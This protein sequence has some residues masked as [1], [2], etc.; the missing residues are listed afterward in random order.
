MGKKLRKL[1]IFCCIGFVFSG[2][3]CAV[4]HDSL[5][6]PVKILGRSL[7]SVAIL[8][9]IKSVFSTGENSMQQVDSS[10]PL[11]LLK[12]GDPRLYQISEP[13]DL[14]KEMPLVHK[15]L[16]QMKEVTKGI[17][18]V[19]IAAPQIGIFKLMVMFEIPKKHLRYKT[20]G[21][22]MPMRVMINPSYKPLS[23][24]KNFEW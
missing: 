8:C 14:P 7:R 17:G 21:I 11:R 20:D 5:G 13:I 3:I 4:V 9:L 1:I 16:E 23:D 10:R 18:N 22:A 12:F 15:I 19:G 24:E 6:Q 2:D